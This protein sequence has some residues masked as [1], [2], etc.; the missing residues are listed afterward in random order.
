VHDFCASFFSPCFHA[1]LCSQ[2]TFRRVS[3]QQGPCLEQPECGNSRSKCEC[4]LEVAEADSKL[5]LG[6]TNQEAVANTD[7]MAVDTGL[8]SQAEAD[9]QATVV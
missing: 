3:R 7:M 1:S 9:V 8:A 4:Q 6:D 5:G 2:A